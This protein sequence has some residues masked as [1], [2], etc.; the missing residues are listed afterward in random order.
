MLTF[1]YFCDK[2]TTTI[3]KE[4]IMRTVLYILALLLFAVY[5]NADIIYVPGDYPTIQEGI[6][7]ANPGDIVMV[8]PGV[9]VEE[10]TLKADVSVIGAGEGQSIIDGG[11]DQGDVVFASGNTITNSTLFKGFTVTG[12]NYGGMPGGGGIFCNTGASPE[13][14]NNRVEVNSTGIATWNGSNP[15][16]H[17]NVIIDNTYTGISVSSDPDVINNTIANNNN[18][19]YD[20]GGYQPVIMNN[21]VTGNSNIGMGCVNSSVPTD[22]SYNDVW[23]NGQNYYNCSPGPGDISADPL[24]VDEPNGDFHLQPTSPCIDSGN[25]APQYNDPDGSRNDMGAYGGPDA[26]FNLP[27]VSLTIPS[28]NELNVNYNTDVS[29]IFTVDMEPSTF[30]SQSFKINSTMW[31]LHSGSVTYDSAS[32]MVTIDPDSNF[33]SGEVATALL[34][35][36]IESIY[37]D[38]ISGY[39]WQ[40]TTLV[41]TGSAVFDS[42]VDY[43]AGTAPSDVVIADFDRDSNLDMAAVNENSGD[44][45][46]LMGNGD[47]TFGGATNY[48]AGSTPYALVTADFNG[49]GNLDLAVANGGSDNVSILMGNGD[50]TFG[51]ANNYPAGNVPNGLCHSD[52]NFD[53]HLDLA[54]VNANSDDVSILLGN[55]DGSF[56]G[57]TN[58][59]V[60]TSPYSICA[61]DYNND[62]FFDLAAAN[63]GSNN[64]SVLLG[65]GNGG[66]GTAN[67]FS[68]GSSPYSVCTGDFNED[69]NLDLGVGNGGSNNI[70]VL[71]GDGSGS[72]SSASNYSTDDTPYSIITSDFN[73]D[74]NLDLGVVNRNSNNTSILLGGGDG[75]FASANN[76]SCGTNPHSLGGGDFDGDG[77]IDICTANSGD[78]NIS[79][80]LNKNELLVVSTNPTQYELDVLKSSNVSGTFNMDLNSSTIDSSSFILYG[81]QTGLHPGVVDYDS[82]TFTATLNPDMDFIDGEVLTALLTEDIQS[83]SGVFLDGFSWR[84]CAQIT[85]PS[86]GTF[87]NRQ[88]YSANI[89]PRG[90]YAGEL[91]GDNDI[92][93]AATLNQGAVAIYVNNGDGTFAN[94]T[95]Y[96]IS[97]EPIAL[98]GADL[99]SDGDIDLASI[100]NRPG[101]ANLDI[102][103]NN[104]DATFVLGSS[105]TLSVMGNSISGSDLDADGDI[106]LVLSSYWSSSD[107]VDVMLNNGDATF[108]GPYVYTAG[109]Y[110]HGIIAGDVDNDGD[111]DICVVNSGD[112][113]VSILS[114][115]GDGN[116]SDLANFPV[117]SGPYSIYGNDLS[118]DGYLDLVSANYGGDNVAVI[119][120]NGNGTFGAP[121]LYSTG[122]NTRYLTGGDVDGDGDIDLVTSNNGA[123]SISVLI[124]NGDGTFGNRTDYQVGTTPWGIRCADFDLDGDLDIAC[125]NYNADN[126][127]VLFNT[128]VGIK[129]EENRLKITKPFI[130]IFPN[131]FNDATSITY[132]IGPN[133]ENAELNIYDITGRLVKNFILHPSSFIPPAKLKWDGKDSKGNILPS[134]V[135]FCKLKT[136]KEIITSKILYVR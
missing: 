21:I 11:D 76:F 16:I 48:S 86:D 119:I 40:F 116:F 6:D 111:M 105:Y 3:K 107:N 44:L 54:V 84:F 9:Y 38:S 27:E 101:T 132:S 96:T 33:I 46:I 87:E 128:G 115:D 123:D 83:S 95:T 17:N 81:S 66:F 5:V 129:E 104:G 92:D 22:F 65:D 133:I 130:K 28:Q 13:I 77:D 135:Y 43:S 99:D 136:N 37:G 97:E 55:G 108:S 53:G 120:N 51:A 131:P 110:A 113:N 85:T 89:E 125:A 68:V 78:N 4:E 114:N 64:V 124:N 20:S 12:A 19:I 2:L 30:S 88:D 100:N 1:F 34:T 29:A 14:C 35:K 109:T 41:E 93:I 102:L 63:G 45:S 91:D 58:Y 36:G 127:S 62:G 57:A 98:F 31:G 42:P 60:S 26:E 56:G 61:G 118:G 106:D 50:G 23:G 49:D 67:N 90:L 103:K 15:Y 80:L 72:F 32:K 122:S 39:G 8:A 75:S 10:I 71:M 18:G 117:G 73:G 24:Y 59:S 69:G 121:A 7:A 82:I 94:P 134:G 112:D 52:F 25:P 126:I 79:I 74:G 70:S 47:G